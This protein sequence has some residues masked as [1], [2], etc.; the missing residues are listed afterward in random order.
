L[1]FSESPLGTLEEGM[2]RLA[3]VINT[4]ATSLGTDVSGQPRLYNVF[5]RTLQETP[6]I[7]SRFFGEDIN[8]I[9]TDAFT[10]AVARHKKNGKVLN[11]GSLFEPVPG[12]EKSVI[13]KMMDRVG[14]WG[15]EGKPAFAA[16]TMIVESRSRNANVPLSVRIA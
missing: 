15:E 4:D 1:K 14:H 7:W 16:L 9:G 12:S 11:F 10:D 8:G 6:A 2:E 3:N 13:Q 5:L